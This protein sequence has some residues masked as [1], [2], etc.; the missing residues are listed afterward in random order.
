MLRD[1]GFSAI[2]ALGSWSGAPPSPQTR[3]ILRARKAK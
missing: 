2:D 3:L 1:A